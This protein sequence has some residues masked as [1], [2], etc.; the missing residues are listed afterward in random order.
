MKQMTIIY[1][2]GSTLGLHITKAKRKYTRYLEV[3]DCGDY[4]EYASYSGYYRIDKDTL[5]VTLNNGVKI[6]EKPNI[7]IEIA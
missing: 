7:K 5:K 2:D 3:R 1:E 4:Y 6:I